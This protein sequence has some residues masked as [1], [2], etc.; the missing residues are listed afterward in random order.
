[1]RSVGGDEDQWEGAGE[2]QRR[3]TLEHRDLSLEDLDV[4][5]RN[6]LVGQWPKFAVEFGRLDLLLTR[7]G[8]VI[9]L[10]RRRR[11]LAFLF[12][13]VAV[14]QDGASA[15]DAPGARPHVTLHSLVEVVELQLAEAFTPVVDR[16]ERL[17]EE[18]LRRIALASEL[19]L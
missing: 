15:A 2:E 11:L 8:V 4:E 1:M 5:S 14:V 10:R 16:F 6:L 9:L 19:S 12:V 7:L 13:I 17:V 3:R 18:L